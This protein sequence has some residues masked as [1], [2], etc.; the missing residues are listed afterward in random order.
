MGV[1]DAVWAKALVLAQ[2]ERKFTVVTADVLAFPPG[3][4]AAVIERL[5]TNG[6]SSNQVLLLP[7]HSHTSIDMMALHPGNEFGI[8]Q[9]GIFQK[10]LFERTA[11]Q[12]AKVIRD[13][14]KDLV[15]MSAASAAI[16]VPD[17]NRNRRH[18][19]ATHDTDLTVTRVDTTDGRPLAVLVN[20]TAHPTFMD[21][22]DMLFSGDWPGHLQRTMEALI[23]H[24]VSVMFYNG[25]EGDQSPVP[26]PDCGSNWERAERYGRELGIIAWRAWEKI[27]PQ[28]VKVFG[29]HTETIVLPK[30]QSHPDFMKTGGAEYGLD[31]ARRKDFLDRLVP[32]QTH[33]TCLRLG[34][35]VVLGVPGE[36][37]AQLGSEA[38]SKTRQITGATCVTIAGLADEWVSYILPAEEY[39]KA[40]YEASMSFYGETLGNTLVEG[41]IH[42]ARGLK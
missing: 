2:D 23:G 36:M 1:H 16:S 25:A 13:A 9:I 32:A 8:P 33:S 38:K 21:A 17:R 20:W 19:G 39:R 41:V 18:G 11:D 7:S 34:D 28:E 24:G 6:W 30:R 29:Y 3:F 42:G 40:G 12:L 35:L 27:Q 10:E 14:G 26:P 37:T 4:K 5:A 15:S 22:E 31:E